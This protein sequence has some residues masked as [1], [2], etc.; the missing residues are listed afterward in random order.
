[1]ALRGLEERAALALRMGE[2][3]RKRGHE[4]TADTFSRR[5]DEAQAAALLIRRLLQSGEIEGAGAPAEAE[6]W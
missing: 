3:A 6:H 4:H 5:H 1:M 2:R